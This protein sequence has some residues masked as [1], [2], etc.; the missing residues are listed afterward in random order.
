[1]GASSGYGL[2][3]GYGAGS[4]GKMLGGGTTGKNWDT[5]SSD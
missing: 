1:M 3:V 4:E 2:G 5:S